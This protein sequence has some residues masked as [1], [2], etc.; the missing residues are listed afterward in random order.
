M[1]RFR[2]GDDRR[3]ACVVRS[4]S[5]REDESRRGGGIDDVPVGPLLEHDRNED[6]RAVND[7]QKVDSRHPL[8]VGGSGFSDPRAEDR[9]SGVV[10]QEVHGPE[11]VERLLG[12]PLDVRD[13]D[14]HAL[15]GA[16]ARERTTD[17]AGGAGDDGHLAPEF[18]YPADSSRV[19]SPR[20]DL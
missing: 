8:P 2:Q 20:S 1:Q 10:E 15:C 17:P 12:D 13:D 11:P 14:L 5:R 18:L 7:T 19:A 6:R 9:D 16:A 3:L 4:E